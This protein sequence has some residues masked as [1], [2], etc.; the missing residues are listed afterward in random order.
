[1]LLAGVPLASA[2]E[3]A[4]DFRRRFAETPVQTE[5]GTSLQ[6]SVS[7]GV[8]AFQPHRHH[9]ADALYHAADSAL[10]EAKAAGRN[11]VRHVPP[12]A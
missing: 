9:D 8:A 2:L 4:D 5:G 10:Y 1:M 11:A 3:R 6:L 7:I 12:L